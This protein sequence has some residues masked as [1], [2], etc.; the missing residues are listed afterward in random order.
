MSYIVPSATIVQFWFKKRLIQSLNG[1]PKFVEESINILL[2]RDNILSNGAEIFL[3]PSRLLPHNDFTIEFYQIFDGFKYKTVHI[4]E[5]KDIFLEPEYQNYLILLGK[6]LN[7][8]NVDKIIIHANF[9]K[10]KRIQKKKLFSNF[11]PDINIIVEN[12]GFDD[13]WGNSINGLHKI[14][15][16]CPEYKFCL[17]IAHV[18]DFEYNDLDVYINDEILNS[19]L[20]EIHLSYSTMQLHCD[21][22]EEKGFCGYKPQHALFSI[23]GKKLSRR[24]K[25]FIKKYPVVIEGL[26]PKEDYDLK[27]LEIEFDSLI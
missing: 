24:T 7:R 8:L 10:Q 23:M 19:R 9:F 14:F 17:D 13:Q 25:K 12:N 6:I 27:Y 21:P 22:Y 1:T 16:D 3:M 15:Q 11:L 20:S 5:Y 2:N 4:N 26:V 18:K